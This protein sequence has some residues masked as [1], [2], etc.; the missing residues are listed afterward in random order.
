MLTLPYLFH[1]ERYSSGSHSQ[2]SDVFGDDSDGDVGG[3]DVG[4]GDGSES[5][6][7]SKSNG[8]LAPPQC[9]YCHIWGKG[10][11]RWGSREGWGYGGVW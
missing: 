6:S 4:A 5:Q 8:R 7:G 2:Y 9:M 1:T 3:G 11:G 10:R